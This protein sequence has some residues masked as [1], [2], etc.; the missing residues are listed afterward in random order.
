MTRAITRAETVAFAIGLARE[1]LADY[2][3]G[4]DVTV[5]TT[6][7][8]QIAATGTGSRLTVTVTIVDDD[9]EECAA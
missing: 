9:P 7:G 1:H 3:P 8:P 5:T 2:L 6:R 4:A